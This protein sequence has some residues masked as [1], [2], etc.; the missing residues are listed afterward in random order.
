MTISTVPP[1]RNLPISQMRYDPRFQVE[2]KADN[3]DLAS[4]FRLVRRR[5]IMII[6]IT[7]LLM[8]PT[9]IIISGL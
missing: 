7:A 8:A 2:T 1:D 6:A 3:F 9:V 4:A 5:M